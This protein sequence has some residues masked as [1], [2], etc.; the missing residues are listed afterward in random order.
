MDYSLLKLKKV[1]CTYYRETG[2][3]G[4]G[5]IAADLSIA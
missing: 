2:K 3:T 5:P 4:E 1:N